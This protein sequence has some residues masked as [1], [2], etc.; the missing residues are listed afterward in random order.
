MDTNK[1][2]GFLTE[3]YG[4][5]AGGLFFERLAQL[6]ENYNVRISASDFGGIDQRDTIL[7]VYPDQVRQEGRFPLTVST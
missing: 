5:D 2:R 6:L 3:L 4:Q 1:I 7:I